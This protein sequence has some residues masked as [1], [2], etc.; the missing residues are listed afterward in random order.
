MGVRVLHPQRCRGGP[1]GRGVPFKTEKMG[2]RIPSAAPG[3]PAG[4]GVRHGVPALVA[5]RQRHDVEDVAGPGSNPGEGTAVVAAA[6]RCSCPGGPTGRGR[7]L[8]NR[9]GAGST[10]ALTADARSAMGRRQVFHTCEAGSS[11][12]RA[13]TAMFTRSQSWA[14]P[15]NMHIMVTVAQRQS[16]GL[17]LRG[18][19]VR[20][21]PVTPCGRVTVGEVGL[22]VTRSPNGSGG[23]NPSARTTQHPGVEAG[24]HLPP[25]IHC[26]FTQAGAGRRVAP[27]RRLSR[28]SRVG[29]AS[30]LAAR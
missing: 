25:S 29:P 13:T 7:W 1:T 30:R 27:P 8:K 11:P 15:Q 22:A 14:S 26:G 9:C 28:G 18:L 24:N 19:P 4:R 16:T 17:W 20:I 10:P 3:H 23:S 2:V 21:R 5:Q 6:G 12:A